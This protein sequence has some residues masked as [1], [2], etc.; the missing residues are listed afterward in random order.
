MALLAILRWWHHPLP[1]VLD[2][3]I[4]ALAQTLLLETLLHDRL[5]KKTVWV[6]QWEQFLS[7]V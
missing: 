5:K 3:L 7:P 2:H 6:K 1:L 4:L